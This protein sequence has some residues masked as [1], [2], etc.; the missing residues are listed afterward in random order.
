MEN[1][2]SLLMTLIFMLGLWNQWDGW[3]ADGYEINNQS[4]I[5]EKLFDKDRCLTVLKRATADAKI[6]YHQMYLKDLKGEPT[7]SFEFCMPLSTTYLVVESG[8]ECGTYGFWI[9]DRKKCVKQF[10]TVADEKTL[11]RFMRAV[12]YAKFVPFSIMTDDDRLVFFSDSCI[13]DKKGKILKCGMHPK[14]DPEAYIQRLSSQMIPQ[15]LYEAD[16]GC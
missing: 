2:V 10:T 16:A 13:L 5:S 7:A 9:N 14:G 3:K 6:S 1:A 15:P 11:K 4:D 8:I 12:G